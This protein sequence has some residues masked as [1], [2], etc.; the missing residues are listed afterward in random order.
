M[1]RDFSSKQVECSMALARIYLSQGLLAPAIEEIATAM[2]IDNQERMSINHFRAW[3]CDLPSLALELWV[4]KLE[5]T[6]E[7]I[8]DSK[9]ILALVRIR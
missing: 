5:V 2:R 3:D 9:F 8:G 4:L 6:G 7:P 1:C